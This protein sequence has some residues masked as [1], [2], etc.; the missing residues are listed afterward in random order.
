MTLPPLILTLRD[1]ASEDHDKMFP[2][3]LRMTSDGWCDQF[4]KWSSDI[5]EASSPAWGDND[6]IKTREKFQGTF[7][8]R[9]VVPAETHAARQALQCPARTQAHWLQRRISSAGTQRC[10]HK[11]LSFIFLTMELENKGG[12]KH[13]MKIKGP[14][15]CAIHLEDKALFLMRTVDLAL[16]K[17]LQMATE[18][19]RSLCPTAIVED[20]LSALAEDLIDVLMTMSASEVPDP[21]CG[22]RP[23]ADKCRQKSNHLVVFG[24]P[25]T[26]VNLQGEP[27]LAQISALLLDLGEDG[28]Q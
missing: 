19:I 16:E 26:V 24:L 18:I 14:I 27:Q 4:A 25:A 15:P 3:V 20:V 5:S 7:L 9:P 22:Q 11:N 1:R 10:R 13:D 21:C 12:Q 8:C 23:V 28:C 2:E 6:Y 17:M